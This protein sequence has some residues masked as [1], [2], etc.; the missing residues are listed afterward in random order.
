MWIFDKLFNRKIEGKS[1]LD[2]LAE[3]VVV[4]KETNTTEIG[5]NLNV[6]GTITQNGQPLAIGT[7][8]Y[9]HSLYASGMDYNFKAITTNPQPIDFTTIDTYQKLY[10]YLLSTN[11]LIFIGTNDEEIFYDINSAKFYSIDIINVNQ[12]EASFYDDWPLSS[13]TDTVSEL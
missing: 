7:K 4:N 6:N 2:D 3:N 12:F 1:S 13:T 10:N 9:K 5:G 8:L 11:L